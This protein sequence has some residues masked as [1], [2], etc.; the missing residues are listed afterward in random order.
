MNIL[1]KPIQHRV[2]LGFLL[3][4]FA[5]M[6]GLETYA[7]DGVNALPVADGAGGAGGQAKPIPLTIVWVAYT[8]GPIGGVLLL[9]SFYFVA[10]VTQLFLEFREQVLAPPE[11]LNDC[12]VLLNKRDF[13]GIY[14][15][16]K[17]SNTEFGRLIAAGLAT[18]STGLSDSREAVDRQ[19][20]MLRK[21][22]H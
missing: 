6:P 18:Y 4:F 22:L 13:N 7:Q 9:I 10:L 11:L 8:S 20:E 17:E 2:W 14:R 15:L 1:R 5:A 12:N 16:A 21:N 3:V 19:G